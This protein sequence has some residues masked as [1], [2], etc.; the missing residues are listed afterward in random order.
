[1]CLARLSGLVQVSGKL[2]T[3]LDI[4]WFVAN[5][6][7]APYENHAL[8]EAGGDH[9]ESLANSAGLALDLHFQPRGRE[10]SR[11]S[12]LCYFTTDPNNLMPGDAGMAGQG[13]WQ[14]TT[15]NFPGG[16]TLLADLYSGTSSTSLV[17]VKTA[18]F[19]NS[20]AVG[21]LLPSSSVTLPAGQPAGQTTY[22]Q[23]SIRD[24]RDVDVGASMAAG[25]YFG[26]SP[27]FTAVPQPVSFANLWTHAS[28]IFSTSFRSDFRSA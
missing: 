7:F 21:R 22:F 17:F 24:S 13:L 19:T 1:M 18:S 14:G 6:A 5:I 8:P 20:L 28:P 23:I 12:Y 27:I 2:E 10:R 15:T 16:A 4:T 26:T 25:H 9:S 3:R 11:Q